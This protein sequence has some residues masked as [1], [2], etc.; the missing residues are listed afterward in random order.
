MQRAYRHTIY[1]KHTGKFTSPKQS[2]L[3]FQAET[4]RADEGLLG[5]RCHSLRHLQHSC[6]SHA[7]VL[8]TSLE[9]IAQNYPSDGFSYIPEYVLLFYFYHSKSHGLRVRRI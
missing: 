4:N 3:V 2:L 7:A 9:D 6:S 1:T 8:L 5:S